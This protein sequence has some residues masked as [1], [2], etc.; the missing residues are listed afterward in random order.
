MSTGKRKCFD[1]NTGVEKNELLSPHKRPRKQRLSRENI[2]FLCRNAIAQTASIVWAST[3]CAHNTTTIQKGHPPTTSMHEL[4]ENRQSEQTQIKRHTCYCYEKLCPHTPTF[5]TNTSLWI[6]VACRLYTYFL[7]G[8]Q[9]SFA[10]MGWEDCLPAVLIYFIASV[11][12][13]TMSWLLHPASDDGLYTMLWV[14]CYNFSRVRCQ[15][16]R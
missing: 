5:L 14:A 2:S 13:P 3:L 8:S 7:S 9:E 1:N 6:L 16:G 11:M 10:I 4:K 12:S 15:R